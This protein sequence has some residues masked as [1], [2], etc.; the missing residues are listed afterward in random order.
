MSRHSE[1]NKKPISHVHAFQC[2][3]NENN[4]LKKTYKHWIILCFSDGGACSSTNTQ[5]AAHCNTKPLNQTNMAS[6]LNKKHLKLV[7][8]KCFRDI[9]PCIQTSPVGF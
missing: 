3:Q 5:T 2:P 7:F 1:G 4:H 9:D 6:L 8:K